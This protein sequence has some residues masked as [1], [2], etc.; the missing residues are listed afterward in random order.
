M[1][2]ALAERRRHQVGGAVH[3][4]RQRVVASVDG[5]EAAKPD[6]PRDTV[7]IAERRLRLG[8]DV[9]RALPSR[10]RACLER[11][12]GPELADVV[13][14]KLAVG[15]ARQLAGDKQQRAALLGAD[16]VGDRRCGLRQR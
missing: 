11:R 13:G 15:A 3:R 2:A 9:D 6:D 7:E 14:G 8:E 10:R 1:A 5:E 12:S 4:L 16:V